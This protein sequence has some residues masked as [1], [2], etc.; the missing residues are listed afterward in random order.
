MYMKKLT[1]SMFVT[2]LGLPL[3]VAEVTRYSYVSGV[4]FT[5]CSCTQTRTHACTE[6]KRAESVHK[7][8]SKPAGN[9]LPHLILL[10]PIPTV[11]LVCVTIMDQITIWQTNVSTNRQTVNKD[12]QNM[13]VR[14]NHKDVVQ[15]DS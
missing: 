14:A 8:K 3:R 7:V 9:N 4:G 5:P 15:A 1:E 13:F 6:R 12:I 11:V 2:Q 10:S